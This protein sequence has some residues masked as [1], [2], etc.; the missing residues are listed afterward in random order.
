MRTWCSVCDTHNCDSPQC[1]AYLEWLS[2]PEVVDY[3][4]AV[5]RLADCK[6][7]SK[8][9]IA[10]QARIS[11]LETLLPPQPRLEKTGS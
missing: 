11:T 5:D 4:R 8:S 3:L 6:R 2:K 10:A 7:G 1:A 9:Y